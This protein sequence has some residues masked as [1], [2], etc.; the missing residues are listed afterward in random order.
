MARP[1]LLPDP[2][3]LKFMNLEAPPDWDAEFGFPGPLELEIGSGA[4][5][6]ALEY[7][8]RNPQVRYVAFEWRKK[9]ARDTQAR[10][11]KMGLKNLR[12]LEADARAV[13]PRLFAAGSLAAIHLQFPD[14]WWKRAHFKR[15]IILPDFARV[16]LDK[17]APGGRFDMRTDVEDRGHAMLSILEEVGFL[18]PL[19]QG[20]FHP[21]D[22]EEVPSTRE[23]R[24]LQSGEPVYRGRLV[25][26]G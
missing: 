16:L 2:V 21:Y 3:G 20:V 22:P 11:E 14:P 13:V 10:G 8:R 15:A 9:Y 6:H 26:P 1:R 19:G 23:R 24:Y 17:L 5:G 7:C 25:K 12:V 4:G 18:N